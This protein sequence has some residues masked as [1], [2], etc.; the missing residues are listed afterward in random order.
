MNRTIRAM[1]AIGN[2]QHTNQCKGHLVIKAGV[3]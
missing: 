2:M 3:H 1:T